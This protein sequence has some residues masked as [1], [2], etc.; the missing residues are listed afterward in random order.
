M[1]VAGR[2]GPLAPLTRPFV[3]RQHIGLTE[4]DPPS[5]PI[6]FLLGLRGSSAMREVAK[7]ERL[8]HR[9]WHYGEKHILLN[10][11]IR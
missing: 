6:C 1:A 4:D 8:C 7:G 2:N 5:K 3:L 11:A 9:P 10:V